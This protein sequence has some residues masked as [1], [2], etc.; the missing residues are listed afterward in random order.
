MA[1]KGRTVQPVATWESRLWYWMRI[2]GI[3]L[4][5]FAGVHVVIKDVIVGVHRIDTNYVAQQWANP[6]I[7]IADFLLLF[8]AYS[9]GMIG[10]RQVLMDYIHGSAARRAMNWLVFLVWLVVSLIGAIAIIGGVR[11]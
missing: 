2:S 6:L 3:L 9:H 4:V 5:F 1:T 11:M 8:L 10:L 7:R